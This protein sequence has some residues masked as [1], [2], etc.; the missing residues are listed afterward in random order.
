[1]CLHRF[2]EVVKSVRV[3]QGEILSS[4][5]TMPSTKNRAAPLQKYLPHENLKRYDS[6]DLV[7]RDQNFPEP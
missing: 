2:N 4:E 5:S 6:N 7:A 1:M 3:E